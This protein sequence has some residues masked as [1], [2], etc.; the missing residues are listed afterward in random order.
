MIKIIIN[1]ED[2]FFLLHVFQISKISFS[3]YPNVLS[4]ESPSIFYLSSTSVYRDPPLYLNSVHFLWLFTS[5]AAVLHSLERKRNGEEAA[6]KRRSVGTMREC[7]E[8]S[9]A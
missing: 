2:L 6:K 4:S 8:L 9:I 3:E 5:S 1:N 7:D